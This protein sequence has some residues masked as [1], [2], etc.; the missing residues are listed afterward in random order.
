MNIAVPFTV[1]LQS[2]LPLI[3]LARRAA[4]LV[5][6]HR[7]DVGHRRLIRLEEAARIASSWAVSVQTQCS[8]GFPLLAAYG[9]GVLAKDSGSRAFGTESFASISVCSIAFVLP[10]AF[11]FCAS[12]RATKVLA[13]EVRRQLG[14]FPKDLGITR[15]PAEFTPSYRTCVDIAAREST[16]QLSVPTTAVVA[17]SLLFGLALVWLTKSPGMVGQALAMYL[18]QVAVAALAAGFVFEVASDFASTMRA[19][20]SRTLPLP[21]VSARDCALHHLAVNATPAVRLLAKISVIAALT[22][23]PYMF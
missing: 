10:V 21:D 4:F 1:T 14:G 17:P 13:N 11:G 6:N 3:V 12:S 15:I 23:V 20:S 18:G 7:D 9:I 22:F 2:T 16:R 19:R 5:P 8:V